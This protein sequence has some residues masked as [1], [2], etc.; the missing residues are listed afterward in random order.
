METDFSKLSNYHKVE[1]F[2]QNSGPVT[3]DQIHEF[4]NNHNMP[5]GMQICHD[6]LAAKVIEEIDGWYRIKAEDRKR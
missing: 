4:I 1:R 3:R 6:L 2:I 5:A